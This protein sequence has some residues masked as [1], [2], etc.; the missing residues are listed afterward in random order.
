MTDTMPTLA[1]QSI[2]VVDD[3]PDNL[4]VLKTTLEIMHSARVRVAS[5][6]DDAIA[7]LATFQPTMVVTD[8]SMPY[9]DGY[10]LLELLRARPDTA[11][12]PIIAVT[13]HAMKGDREVIVAAG[14]DGYISK[15]FEVATVGGVLETLLQEFAARHRTSIDVAVPTSSQPQEASQ[16]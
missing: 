16:S 1:Q 15:P 2:L 4:E 11:A 8:I 12:L 10:K 5:S 3:E 6:C 14:F 13:A 7:Q 9:A